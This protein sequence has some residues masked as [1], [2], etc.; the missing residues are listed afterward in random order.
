M[1]QR[2][3]S[4]LETVLSL[5]LFSLLSL[6]L[7][8]SFKLGTDLWRVTDS[9]TEGIG[10]LQSATWKFERD[11]LNTAA[12]RIR[13]KRVPFPGNGD[14]IWLLSPLDPNEP[15]PQKEQFRRD[16][17]G[18]PIW[19][20]NILYYLIRPTNHDQ[21]AGRP[22]A[23]D[24]DINGDAICPHKMLV[25][26]VINRPESPEELLSASQI[27]QYLTAPNGFDVSA[28]Q[29]EPGLEEARIIGAN[30]LWFEA[31][32]HTQGQAL[33]DVDLRAVS[34]KEAIKQLPIGQEPLGRFLLSHRLTIVPG[35]RARP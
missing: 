31:V 26:K 32:D 27:E 24:P 2:G 12:D 9:R 10:R 34:L 28:F 1:I 17:D 5:G 7:F 35:V 29:G 33:V 19:Q 25:R 11:L 14:A 20:R 4:L 18:N 22:C 6:V 23:I 3:F 13:S 8:G 21:I 30:M 15:D 16:L